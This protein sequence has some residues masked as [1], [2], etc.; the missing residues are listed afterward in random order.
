VAVV[1]G[2]GVMVMAAAAWRY[3]GYRHTRLI[4]FTIIGVAIGTLVLVVTNPA[5]LPNPLG[6]V[7]NSVEV[8]RDFT[9]WS[10]SVLVRGELYPSTAIPLWYLPF[11][12]FIQTPLVVLVAASFG[13]V[14]LVRR[15]VASDSR[16]K[17]GAHVLA[18]LPV[19]LQVVP[20]VVGVIGG[21]LFYNAG[22]QVLFVLPVVALFAGIGVMAVLDAVRG[23]K[24][25]LAG[26]RP[27]VLGLM[28][29][30]VA[31][32]VIDTV[33]L[34]PYQYVYFNE[35][36]RSQDVLQ[37]YEF[38]Y[39]GISGREAMDWVN[40]TSPEAAIKTPGIWI[41]PPFATS[42]VV[43]VDPA[44]ASQVPGWKKLNEDRTVV[45][46]W[47]QVPERD[48]LWVGNYY[49]VWGADTLVDCPVVHTVTRPLWN[50]DIVL[51]QVRR[52][53]PPSR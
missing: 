28:V 14:H 52:C 45:V 18:W 12:V 25:P 23:W 7:L 24:Q 2:A 6:W 32:P 44:F 39:W 30:L 1:F 9:F 31:L 11:I 27:V 50:R 4:S 49:P 51:S 5:S 46:D 41:Y 43:L 22:R 47:S 17:R 16:G 38:D 3:K 48:R 10:G 15:A 53:P 36:E 13:V 37:R 34:F 35:L 26:L 19:G 33:R 29:V 8:A 20:A 40:E 21:S 42:D